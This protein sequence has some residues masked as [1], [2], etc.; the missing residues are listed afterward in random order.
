MSQH[1][2]DRA[3]LAYCR[4]AGLASI[5]VSPVGRIRTG[6][7]PIHAGAV[8][9]W[10][11]KAEDVARVAELARVLRKQAPP[12]IAIIRA[13]AKLGVPLTD[14]ATAMSRTQAA[15]A[16]LGERLDRANDTGALAPFNAEFRR[17]RL[18]AR[19][20]G[21]RFMSYNQARVQLRAVLEA[22]AGSGVLIGSVIAQVFDGR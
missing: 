17:R 19:A 18:A 9:A 16:K 3:A 20:R 15:L 13:A 5:F 22:A 10:W 2:G 11:V 6:P 14:H 12:P 7:D 4:K 8:A 21:E 1:G